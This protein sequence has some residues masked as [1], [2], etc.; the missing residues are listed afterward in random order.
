M[1]GRFAYEDSLLAAGYSDGEVR[2]FNMNTDNKISQIS[3][4]PNKK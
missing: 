1:V 2:V 4:N 3:T